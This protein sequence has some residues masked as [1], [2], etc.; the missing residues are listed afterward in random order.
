MWN[1]GFNIIIKFGDRDITQWDTNKV[2][3]YC[4]TIGR[5]IPAHIGD[6][7]KDGI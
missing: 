3:L 2:N 4:F 1:F 7:I 6:T 5:F